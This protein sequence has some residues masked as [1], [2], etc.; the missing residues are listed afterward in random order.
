MK[1]KNN[2]KDWSATA[3]TLAQALPFMQRYENAIIVIKLGGHAMG[4][5]ETLNLFARDVVLMK[6]V[7]IN[8]I[9]VHG[10][11]P[12]INEMLERLNIKSKFHD[13]KRITDQET[14]EVVEMVLSGLINKKIVQA[15]N[16][17][18]GQAV[19]LSG[20]D[21]NLMYCKKSKGTLGL[22]GTPDEVNT[23]V[24][25]TLFN[26]GIVPIVSPL[27]AGKNGE[28]YNVNGDTSA[29]A[30]AA[31]LKADRLLILTDVE[32]VKDQRG[33]VISELTF[34]EI[35]KMLKNGTI[36]GG[37]IPKTETAMRALD[38]GVR[39]AVILDGRTPNACLLELFTENGIG[40]IIRNF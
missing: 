37:M 11:G 16:Q 21:A 17:Q 24:L 20:K 3:K 39:A 12:K 9:V 36:A 8:P 25:H 33:R 5:D 30:I 23:E 1:L 18:G 32:G 4:T 40:T 31:A 34:V 6:Q 28:T 35:K 2:L 38:G 14:I 13:G 19:G 22:V 29:G 10:G 27:G 26:N 15:I 7:G